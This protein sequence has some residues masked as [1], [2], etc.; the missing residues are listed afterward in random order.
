MPHKMIKTSDITHFWTAALQLGIIIIA[1]WAMSLHSY[2][3][4]HTMAEIVS[5]VFAVAIFLVAWNARRY[6]N[7]NYYIL[8]GFG[9][10][11]VG[12][13]D[14]FHAFEY[15]GLGI[16]QEGGNANVATQLWLAGR[17]LMAL[18]FLGAA[19]LNNQKIKAATIF[20]VF[21]GVTT[22]LFLSIFY[23]KIFPIAYVD[24]IGLTA[25]KKISE[26]V[27]ISLFLVTLVF[28]YRMRQKFHGRV[29]GLL[30]LVLLIMSLTE[31]SFTL[32]VGVYDFFNLL[33]HLLKIVA[34]YLAYIGIV[35]YGLMNPYSTIF[36]DLKDK[37]AVLLESEE[38]YRSLVEFS[39][40]AIVVHKNGIIKYVNGAANELFGIKGKESLTG[41]EFVE[42]FQFNYRDMVSQRIGKIESGELKR[43]P[44]TEMKIIRAGKEI[45]DVEIKGI[46]IMFNGEQAIES[47]ITDITERKQ[48]QEKIKHMASFPALNPNPVI[49]ISANGMVTY[50]N[51]AALTVLSKMGIK[52]DMKFFFPS[53]LSDILKELNVS[54]TEKTLYRE[55][56]IKHRTFAQSIY[57]NK[58]FNVVRLYI[59]EI[60]KRK[61]AE[62]K[63]QRAMNEWVLMFNSIS[64]PAF[65][66]GVNHTVKYVNKAMC[67]FAGVGESE[68][69]GKK[70]FEFMHKQHEPWTTCPMKITCKS[71]KPHTEEIYEPT[72]GKTLLITTSP[73]LDDKGE[74]IGILHISKDITEKK[75]IE[76][77]K[78]EFISLASHQLRTPLASISL[79]SEL[80]LRGSAGSA[81]I[82]Q[83]EM[84][85]DIYNSTKRMSALIEHMLNVSR[86]ELGTLA[87]KLEP[88]EIVKRVEEIIDELESQITEKKLVLKKEFENGLSM[89]KFDENILRI[90]VENLLVNAIRYTASGGI[91]TVA[92][93]KE[94]SHIMLS[95]C[96][97]GCGISKSQQDRI[98]QKSFRGENAKQISADGHGLGLYMVKEVADK[99]G[100]KISFVS[101]E[102]KG[103]TFFVSFKVEN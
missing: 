77:A 60:T 94:K 11:F 74:I 27:I 62:E 6:W 54:K 53:D 69:V 47:I 93:A 44:L 29:F 88:M 51:D 43:T 97:T 71:K 41:K 5:V 21:A 4:F 75:K 34:Y 67:D 24:G 103:T 19:F 66:L 17:F 80:L 50:Y 98:F 64:D 32:Y 95:V 96:D 2:V 83:K 92:L 15:K 101:E 36:K 13:I 102:N 8:I 33:G 40:D 39:P 25:F 52:K 76:K 73:I 31:I 28:F 58:Q 26:Y 57:L 90:I 81:D 1:L 18:A 3:L 20:S 63:V 68:L 56:T 49:E 16:I 7:N 86:I 89:I 79:A 78:D 46:K 82:E 23:W 30:S 87:I 59:S 10:L 22:L 35:E 9:F 99:T 65:I 12:I 48:S 42:S 72:L 91:I 70:C 84:L 55:I 38:R 61:Q 14:L 85:D 37:E 100:A 45:V